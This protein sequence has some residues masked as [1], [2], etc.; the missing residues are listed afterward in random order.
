MQDV[1]VLYQTCS[2]QKVV[3]RFARTHLSVQRSLLRT[4]I[5]VRMLLLEVFRHRVTTVERL[6][7]SIVL[8]LLQW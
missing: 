1:H 6:M 3:L 4:A 7:G 2:G 8:A 5:L